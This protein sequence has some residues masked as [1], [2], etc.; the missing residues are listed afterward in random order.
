MQ[1]KFLPAKNAVR[2]SVFPIMTNTSSTERIR[3][4]VASATKRFAKNIIHAKLVKKRN[5]ELE[6]SVKNGK[7]ALPIQE[8]A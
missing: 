3:V 6:K 2:R 4:I 5:I 8:F 7:R 1:E